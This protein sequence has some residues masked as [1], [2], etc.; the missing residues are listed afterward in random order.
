MGSEK[1]V[2]DE[3]NILSVSR[4]RVY[5]TNK[6]PFFYEILEHIIYFCVYYAAAATVLFAFGE[7]AA[8]LWGI[9]IFPVIILM[10]IIKRSVKKG[11][12]YMILNLMVS[13]APLALPSGIVV[14]IVFTIILFINFIFLTKQRIKSEEGFLSFPGLCFC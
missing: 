7:Q 3:V 1:A 9:L 4:S 11:I 10:A 12:I 2:K 5:I 8:A 14:K 6:K 13:A